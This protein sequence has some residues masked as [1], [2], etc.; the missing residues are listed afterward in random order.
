MRS[1]MGIEW[2]TT[3]AAGDASH[4]RTGVLSIRA[5]QSKHAMRRGLAR[6]GHRVRTSSDRTPNKAKTRHDQQ[7]PDH[8]D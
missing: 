1:R 3:D 6:S 4:W 2:L 5:G 7:R 8:Q